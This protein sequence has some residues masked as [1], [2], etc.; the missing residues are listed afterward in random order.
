MRRQ[1]SA[2]SLHTRSP[3]GMHERVG[4]LERAVS[5]LAIEAKDRAEALPILQEGVPS[6]AARHFW[7]H[8]DG[9]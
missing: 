7:Y 2:D 6:G 3:T 1:I 9:T 5:T 4:I 8:A